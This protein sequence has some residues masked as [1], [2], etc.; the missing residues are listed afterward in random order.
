[1][2]RSHVKPIQQPDDTTC[3]PVALKHALS[4]F[5]RRKSLEF[6]MELCATNR[7]GTSTRN[8]IRAA[9]K[10]GFSVLVVQYAT[11]HHLQSA[12]KYLSNQVRAVLVSYLYDL[13]EKDRPHPDSGHWAVVSSYRPSK[14]RIVLLDSAS[15]RKKSYSW[16]D[17]RAR[18]MDFDLKRRKVSGRGNHFKLVR[19]WQQQLLFVMAKDPADLPKFRIGSSR[20]FTPGDPV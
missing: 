14:S 2:G 20:V 8:M 4:I 12:L 15:A 6:L 16:S 18:W 5:G 19:R 1:M 9:N 10:L 17:F 7:N 13:D 3:G 11:L